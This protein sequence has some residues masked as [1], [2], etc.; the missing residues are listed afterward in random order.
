MR[1]SYT[2]YDKQHDT[3]A[4]G[5]AS[6]KTASMHK[7]IHEDSN[8]TASETAVKASRQTRRRQDATA[9][10]QQRIS[11]NGK[12]TPARHHTAQQ[13]GKHAAKQHAYDTLS[14]QH[15]YDARRCT[16]A[17]R[18][19]QARRQQYE[20]GKPDNKQSCSKSDGLEIWG[21]ANDDDDS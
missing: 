15:T 11:Q 21:D 4:Y 1:Q 20:N 19:Q 16:H 3:Y 10:T 12:P 6:S 14:M 5:T 18:S 7:G 8:T 2:P 13:R 9:C 17:A